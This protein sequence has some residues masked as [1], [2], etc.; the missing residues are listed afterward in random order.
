MPADR[1]LV[2]VP[3]ALLA[4]NAEEALTLGP[5]LPRTRALLAEWLGRPVALPSARQY[6]LALLALTAAVFL[7]WLAARARPAAAR[8]L[9]V[10]QAVMALNVLWH[11]AAAIVLGGY[12]PGVVTA[13]LVEAPASVLVYRWW[14]ARS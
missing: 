2:V 8:A 5:A 4:H 9:V 7:L 12:A 11:V 13:V 6:Q 10:V 1:P 14:R 3:L